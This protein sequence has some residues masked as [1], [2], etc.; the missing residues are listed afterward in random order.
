[1]TP[2][3]KYSPIVPKPEHSTIALSGSGNRKLSKVGNRVTE[4]VAVRFQY[5][6]AELSKIFGPA[7]EK[8]YALP[9]RLLLRAL[10]R[11]GETPSFYYGV[12]K[13]SAQRG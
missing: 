3:K 2:N 10:S 1:V 4:A 6:F 8:D 5:S 12:K 9:R 13:R 7:I 11:D